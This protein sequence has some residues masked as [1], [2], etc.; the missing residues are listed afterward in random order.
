QSIEQRRL[1][2]IRVTDQRDVP[3][4]GAASRAALRLALAGDSS[5]PGLQHLDPRS[6]QPPV[7]LELRLAGSAQADAAGLPFEVRPAADQPRRQMLQLR[8]LDLKLAF[9]A[10]RALRKNIED[11]ADAVDDAALQRTLE[12][13]LLRARQR[14][15]EDDEVGVGRRAP[16]ADFFDLAATGEECRV[17][18]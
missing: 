12:V 5:E 2:G 8:E 16:R 3:D 10:L 11:Q 15:V 13:A 9:G 17:G 4:R 6:D 1:A 7:G 18:P 14:V